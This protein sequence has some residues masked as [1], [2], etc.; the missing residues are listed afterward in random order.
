VLIVDLDRPGG[1]LAARLGD[2]AP[3]P[4]GGTDALGADRASAPG[5]RLP[6]AQAVRAV[7]ADAQDPAGMLAAVRDGH[8]CVLIHA[9]ALTESGEALRV[10][11]AVDAVI[12]VVRPRH[13]R[14]EHFELALRLLDGANR[15]PDGL[16]VV[17]GWEWRRREHLPAQVTIEP[18]PVAERPREPPARRARRAQTRPKPRS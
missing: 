1:P 6:P 12:V 7:A 13:T 11:G 16:L 10:L 15:A 5:L 4:A 8:D 14:L 3:A 9:P 2:G 17:A 18:A